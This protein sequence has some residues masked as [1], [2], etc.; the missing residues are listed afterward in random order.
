M[1]QQQL[2]DQLFTEIMSITDASLH[3]LT[4]EELDNLA[5]IL[6]NKFMLQLAN[7]QYPKPL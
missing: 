3:E 1:T 6:A 7:T 4:I 2:F 5:F